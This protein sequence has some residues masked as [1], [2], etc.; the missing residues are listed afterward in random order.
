MLKNKITKYQTRIRE[1]RGS[2]KPGEIRNP[3][4]NPNPNIR[5]WPKPGATTE[6]GKFWQKLNVFTAES[7]AKTLHAIRQCNKCPL[8][9]IHLPN[10][11]IKM[12]CPHWSEGSKKCVIPIT[13]FLNEC[14]IIR[15]TERQGWEQVAKLNAM[16]A[17]M[18]TE[19]SLEKDLL[20]TGGPGMLTA[21]FQKISGEQIHNIQKIREGEKQNVNVNANTLDINALLDQ[22]KQKILDTTP[23]TKYEDEEEELE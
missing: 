11:R 5:D 23:I 19:M 22:E 14:K 10:G 12:I 3:K 4:G 13:T 20:T 18:M 9:P 7:K 1:K 8:Q 17:M 16:K 6:I 2:I 21:E 15:E